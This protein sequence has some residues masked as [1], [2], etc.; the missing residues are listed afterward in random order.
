MQIL[1]KLEY[2]SLLK[3]EKQHQGSDNNSKAILIPSF[4]SE[5]L[6]EFDFYLHNG[7]LV[8]AQLYL[9]KG[10]MTDV[11]KETKGMASLCTAT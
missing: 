5:P 7:L 6:C 4:P 11:L 8:Q 9:G 2:L 10:P 1:S 3:E